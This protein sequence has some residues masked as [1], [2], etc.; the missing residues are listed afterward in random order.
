MKIKRASLCQG[1]GSLTHNLR[2]FTANNV[3]KTRTKD[4][5]VFVNIPQQEMYERLFNGAVSEYNAR[6]KR[7]DRKITVSYYEHQFGRGYSPNVV[8]SA[9]KR[10]SFYEDIVQIGD[11][12][13]TGVGTVD[14]ETAKAVLT[15]YMNGFEQRN[16]NFKVFCAVLHMDEATPHLHID[17]V[18]IGHYSR[19]I[20]VQNGIA[21]ALSEMGFGVGKNAIARW[22][23]SEYEVLKSI[24]M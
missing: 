8:T 16:P 5:I 17:Y 1:K 19:G 12:K 9:D 7:N 15:E 24:C 13:D 4:N 2:L 20:P 23:R 18:P 22:R 11:M 21:L 14:A 10:K 3:D 6:Q